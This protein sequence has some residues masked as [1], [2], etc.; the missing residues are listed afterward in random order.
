MND[1]HHK[2][3]YWN[4]FAEVCNAIV[5]DET[6]RTVVESL[7]TEDIDW[8]KVRYRSIQDVNEKGV[9]RRMETVEERQRLLAQD[10]VG[11]SDKDAEYFDLKRYSWSSGNPD[12]MFY[13]DEYSL[14][15]DLTEI[16]SSATE[17][18]DAE[19]KEFINTYGERIDNE[20]TTFTAPITYTK[21]SIREFLDI[22]YAYK[23]AAVCDRIGMD[24]CPM[25][26]AE[27]VVDGVEDFDL[28]QSQNRICENAVSE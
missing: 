5:S 21:G 19:L 2:P 22:E 17:Y 8:H 4:H 14:S 23:M 10:M 28:T 26:K 1:A 18:S 12:V 13:E 11:Y 15:L 3:E 25:T 9:D 24:Y 7:F 16:Q 27:A 6:A 20:H